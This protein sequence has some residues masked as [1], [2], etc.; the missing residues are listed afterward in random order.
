MSVVYFYLKDYVPLQ[1]VSNIKEIEWTPK[2]PIQLLI[3]S[4][5]SGKSSIIREWSP[6]PMDGKSYGEN[7][8]KIVHWVKDDIRYELSS[9]SKN[10]NPRH[11]FKSNGDELNKSGKITEQRELVEVILGYTDKLHDLFLSSANPKESFIQ[12]S[13]EQ[14]RQQLTYICTLDF[15]YVEELYKKVRMDNRDQKGI[16]K[17]LEEKLSDAIHRLEELKVTVPEDLNKQ[18]EELSLEVSSLD[19]FIYRN[20]DLGLLKNKLNGEIDKLHGVKRSISSLKASYVP[21]NGLSTLEDIIAYKGALTANISSYDKEASELSES[22]Y[23]LEEKLADLALGDITVEDLRNRLTLA[24]NELKS[25][26]KTEIQYSYHDKALNAITNWYTFCK[27]IDVEQVTDDEIAMVNSGSLNELRFN[28]QNLINEHRNMSAHLQHLNEHDNMIDCPNCNIRFPIDGI[29]KSA[30]K[31]N[32]ERNLYKLGEAIKDINRK[33]TNLVEITNRVQRFMGKVREVEQLVNG[34]MNIMPNP[35]VSPRDVLSKPHLVFGEY[36]RV[37]R[38]IETDKKRNELLQEINKYNYALESLDGSVGLSDKLNSLKKQHKYL[39]SELAK[40]RNHL[41]KTDNVLHYI[42]TLNE[43]QVI[44]VNIQDSVNR[45]ME[46]FGKALISTDALDRVSKIQ[47]KIGTMVKSKQELD[48]LTQ[49]VDVIRTDLDKVNREH[50]ITNSLLQVLSPSTGITV[51]YLHGFIVSFIDKIN[52]ILKELWTD[53]FIVKPCS[54]ENGK[55]SG[56]FPVQIEDGLVSDLK[57]L[58]KSQKGVFE[59][60]YMLT[61]RSYMN[62]NELPLFMDETGAEFDDSHHRKLIPY[63][64]TILQRNWAKQIILISHYHAMHGT[65]SNHDTVILHKDNIV[66]PSSYV[67]SAKIILGD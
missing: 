48:T 12:L 35:R 62:L 44:L 43:Q 53:T 13:E 4:N 59:F 67:T 1:Y 3:G 65:L 16:K 27:D 38:D 58:S 41:V 26:P 52:L 55:L 21:I 60:A 2:S 25:L 42:N 45:Y 47:L 51:E 34:F 37:K 11:S 30:D 33:E 8:I 56:T 46:D 9:I 18:I 17:H 19:G 22:I 49:Q 39:T 24:R 20:L 64:L 54:I 14:R 15:S 36:E 23:N 61:L 29:D 7:G 32:L 28:K 5:G 31:E 66:V 57:F 10:G 40:A 6:L 63:I 50:D